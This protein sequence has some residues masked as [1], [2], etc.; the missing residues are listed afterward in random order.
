MGTG[1]LTFIAHRDGTWGQGNHE[2]FCGLV[3]WCVVVPLMGLE[4]KITVTFHSCVI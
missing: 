3:L 1:Y 4:R 2:G